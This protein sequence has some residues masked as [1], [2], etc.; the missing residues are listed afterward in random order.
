MR[1]TTRGLY[2]LK[3]VL[4]LAEEADRTNPMP[5]HELAAREQIS[6]EF[7]QQ[8]F[9][10]MRKSGFV[11]ATRGPGG[12]FYLVQSP[13]SITVY[14]I[15]EAAGEPLELT[16][17]ASDRGT[18]KPCPQFVDCKA[19]RFWNDMEQLLARYARS[20]TL[21]DIMKN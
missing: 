12:G 16:P 8:I 4:R 19:G 3:A 13:D 21:A 20:R 18:R 9:Y 1:T 15:L 14:D 10:R 11:A 17:C 7:L 2:A 5:V 6:P